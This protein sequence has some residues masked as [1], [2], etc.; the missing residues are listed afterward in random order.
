MTCF[1]TYL[2]I[3]TRSSVTKRPQF[4]LGGG[5]EALTDMDSDLVNWE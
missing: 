3:G 1:V 5:K 4:L 2:G